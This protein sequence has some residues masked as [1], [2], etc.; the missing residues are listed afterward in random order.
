MITVFTPTYNRANLLPRLYKSLLEQTDKNFEWLIVDDGSKDETEKIVKQWQTDNNLKIR[1]YY[2]KN[3]GKQAAVNYGVRE[4]KGELFFCVDS[5]DLLVNN[6]VELINNHIKELNDCGIAGIVA[7]KSDLEGKVLGDRLPDHIVQCNI[8][9]LVNRHN[10]H[11]EWSI[12]YKTS[13]IKQYPYP[14]IEGEKFIGE[15][16]VYDR[17]DLTYE[18]KLMDQVLTKCEYQDNGLSSGFFKTMINNPVGYKIYYVQRIDMAYSFSQRFSYALRYNAFKHM[19]NDIKYN[20]DGKHKFLVKSLSLCGI[21]LKH[22]Y[23]NRNR[24]VI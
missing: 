6:A 12:I 19:S 11:G 18:M 16:V 7:L 14:I 9:D 5:D 22:Y 3:K 24:G 10:C 20:Y 23:L 2:Q 4:A 17:I 1:Y 15:S 8:F 21:V 13:V